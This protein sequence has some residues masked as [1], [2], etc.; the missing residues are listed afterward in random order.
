MQ[1][2]RSFVTKFKICLHAAVANTANIV[3][4]DAAALL[5]PLLLQLIV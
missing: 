3:V 4:A 5:L 1:I 2:Y